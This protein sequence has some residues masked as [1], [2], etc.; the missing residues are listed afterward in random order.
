MW[1]CFKTKSDRQWSLGILYI[2]LNIYLFAH[3][4]LPVTLGIWNIS[5]VNKSWHSW[6]IA[7]PSSSLYWWTKNNFIR[8]AETIRIKEKRNDVPKQ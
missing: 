5:S 1:S 7:L 6:D 2:Y 8:F 3:C 4:V